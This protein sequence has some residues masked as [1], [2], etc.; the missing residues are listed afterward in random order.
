MADSTTNY[1]TATIRIDVEMYF[2]HQY[3]SVYMPSLIT[4]LQEDW[5]KVGKIWE[6]IKIGWVGESSE[7]ADS[8]NTRLK[9]VQNRLFGTPDKAD[10]TKVETPGILDR[11]RYGAVMAAANYNSAEHAVTNMFDDFVHAMTGEGDGKGPQD[12]TT[13]PITVDYTDNPYPKPKS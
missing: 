12:S 13:P 4:S 10:P 6:A 9:D 8:F 11:V 1:D 5:T 2:M 7:A 3:A